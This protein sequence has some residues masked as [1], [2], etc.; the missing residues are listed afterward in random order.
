ML[1]ALLVLAGLSG[2]NLVPWQK[3]APDGGWRRW[4]PRRVLEPAF[5]VAP[6]DDG[7]PRLELSGR[8]LATVFG[9]WRREVAVSPG[10]NY[11]LRTELQAEAVDSLQRNVICQVRWKGDRVAEEVAPWYVATRLGARGR[12]VCE[13][14]VVAPAGADRAEISLLLQWA[15]RGRVRFSAVQFAALAPGPARIARVATLYWRPGGA[16]TPEANVKAFATLI[17]RAAPQ[18]PDIF[19]LP[20]ALTSI[21][22]GLDVVAAAQPAQ[23]PA[24]RALAERARKYRAYV[25]Y[26][27]YEK[28]G[29]TVY[30]SVFVIGRDGSLV[31]TYRK[32]Q[33]PVGEI[34]AG[35]SPGRVYGVF[36][37]DFGRIG[38]LICHD[39]AFDEPARVLTLAG[40]EILFAPAWGGD[41]TQLRARAMDNGVWLVTSGYDVPSAVIDP[42]GEIR[43]S[44][45]RNE[46]DGIAVKAIDLAKPVLRP[47]VGNWHA[48]VLKQRRPETYR[49]I[50]E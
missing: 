34:E 9:G 43:V 14:D 38:I 17:D 44:T 2:D 32:V 15:P 13:G 48:A 7:V 24:F 40:A 6:A 31:A 27:A 3:A 35:L 41:L 28:E 39:T 11:R 50:A 37:L 19:V 49:G 33:L 20:E 5:S 1:F 36:D 4:S 45:W 10:Q 25:L 12:T 22:T 26:G 29:D 46:G 47:W 21:G 8:G 18:K 42:A 16:S 30:N 23:G